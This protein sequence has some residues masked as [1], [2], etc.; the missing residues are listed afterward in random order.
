ML[1][2]SEDGVPDAF[3]LFRCLLSKYSRCEDYCCLNVC[4]HEYEQG[5]GEGCVL[6]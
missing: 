2:L 4:C 1:A 3:S 6:Y 5:D